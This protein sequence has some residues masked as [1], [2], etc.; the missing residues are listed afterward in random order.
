MQQETLVSY[1]WTEDS[2]QMS[3]VKRTEN[4]EPQN[5]EP[6]NKEPQNQEPKHYTP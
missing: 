5:Q 4:Q 2:G 1:K 3:A 6:Q